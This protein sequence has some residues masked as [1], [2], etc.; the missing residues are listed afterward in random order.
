MRSLPPV[1]AA[2][3]GAVDAVQEMAEAV[4]VF[5]C[6]LSEQ[7]CTMLQDGASPLKAVAVPAVREQGYRAVAALIAS[8]EDEAG[9][10]P[11]CGRCPAASFR[12]GFPR[13]CRHGR[14]KTAFPD[15]KWC[16]LRKLRAFLEK[17]E[18]TGYTIP[19]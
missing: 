17:T 1:W 12:P 13:R 2:T 8:L 7:F 18:Q 6:G 19:N 4:P 14:S 9:R 5:G 10:L 15:K 16:G 3:I 11:N